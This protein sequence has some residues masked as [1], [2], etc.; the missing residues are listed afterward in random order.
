VRASAAALY[1]L[2]LSWVMRLPLFM[3]PESLIPA[4]MVTGGRG[5]SSKLPVIRVRIEPV[6]L[7]Q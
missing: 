6:L 7:C 3:Q 4:E 2:S 1:Q 5:Q